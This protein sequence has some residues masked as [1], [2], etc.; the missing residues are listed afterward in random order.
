MTPEQLALLKKA[1]SSLEAAKLLAGQRYY[2]F[3]VSRAYYSMFYVVEALLLGEGFV[4]SKHSAVIAAFGQ[5]F[6]KTKIVPEEFHK[7]L[8]KAEA[9]RNTGDYDSMAIISA[10]DAMIQIERGEKFLEL[11][12]KLIGHF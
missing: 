3:S 4:Y 2:D 5:K 12:E 6:V 11:A 9:G 1:K 8:I 7:Y 10:D